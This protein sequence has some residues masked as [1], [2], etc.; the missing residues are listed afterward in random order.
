MSPRDRSSD[1]ILVTNI[2]EFLQILVQIGQIVAS[3]FVVGN[4]F[5][6]ALLQLDSLLLKRLSLGSLM[7][8]TRHHQVVLIVISVLGMQSQKFFDRDQGKL[9]IGMPERNLC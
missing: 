3:P 6:F 8:N 9:L 2:D 7:V 1:R 5:L 4:Q